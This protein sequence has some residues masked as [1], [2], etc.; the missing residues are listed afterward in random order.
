[1]SLQKA[2]KYLE[3]KGRNGD[4]MLVHMTPGEVKGLQALAM[5]HG[6]S[7]SVNPHTGLA[8]A[9]FL[10]NILPMIAGAALTPFMGPWGAALA[11]GGFE[12]LRTGDVGKGLMAGMGAFGGGNLATSLSAAAPAAVGNT[13]A[14]SAPSQLATLTEQNL[15]MG[16]TPAE[17]TAQILGSS[18]VPATSQYANEF[19][20]SSVDTINGA[21]P[22]GSVGLDQIMA[23]MN[24][25]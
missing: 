1:M 10:K 11:V 23:L 5:A 8:E 19:R 17:S 25:K 6:G 16:L 20:P 21:L 13:V 12:G 9:S 4:S 2:A 14:S 18:N 22:E 24:G 15:A 3:S 7:L